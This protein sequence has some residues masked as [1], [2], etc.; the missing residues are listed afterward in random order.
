VIGRQRA[1]A[2]RDVLV[3]DIEVL[4][5]LP[6]VDLGLLAETLDADDKARVEG[7]ADVD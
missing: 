7:V 1:D 3:L 4:M 6:V 2:K 5:L